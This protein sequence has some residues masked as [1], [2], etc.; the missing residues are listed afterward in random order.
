MESIASNLPTEGATFR[1]VEVLSGVPRRRRWSEAEKASIVA[2]SLAPGAVGRQVALRHGLHPNQLYMWRRE[3]AC[4][5][6][7]GGTAEGCRFVPVALSAGKMRVPA[8]EVEIEV[9]GAVVRV[10]PGVEIGFLKAV[11]GAVKE[12]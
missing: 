8:G 1:R 10:A 6:A 5:G 11:L 7:V 9:A 2:E 12:A 4:D 3:L